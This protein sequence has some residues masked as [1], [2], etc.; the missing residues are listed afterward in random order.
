MFK[1]VFPYQAGDS[2]LC[3]ST[4]G[5]RDKQEPKSQ[6]LALTLAIAKAPSWRQGRSQ[7]PAS[8]Q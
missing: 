7:G 5:L 6:S 3:V 4:I 1:N 8:K 2:M